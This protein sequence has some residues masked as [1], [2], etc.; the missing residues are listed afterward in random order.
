M[1]VD[2]FHVLGPGMRPK[3]LNT[4][5]INNGMVM[6]KNIYV[7]G[8]DVSYINWMQGQSVS[9]MEDADLVVFTGGEDV[10]P[11]IYGDL[12]HPTTRFNTKRDTYEIAEFQKA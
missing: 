11:A 7:V 8:G 1:R 5:L 4:I 12:P 6:N 3:N 2:Q 10:D 9:K